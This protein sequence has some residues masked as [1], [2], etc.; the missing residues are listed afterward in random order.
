MRLAWGFLHRRAQAKTP[1]LRLLAGWLLL[2]AAAAAA[3]IPDMDSARG[4]QVF[5]SA[6]CI[7][8]HVLNGRGGHVGPNLLSVL[9]RAFTPSELAATMWNHAPTMWS[10][11]SERNVTVTQLTTQ[12]AADLLAMLYASRFF[13]KAGD[14][15][16]G[17]ELFTE[18]RCVQCHGITT[19]VNPKAKPLAQWQGLSDPVALVSANWN[20][21]S[22]MWDEN[23]RKGFHWPTLNADEM[24]DLLVYIRNSSTAARAEK[25]QFH[26]T[27]GGNGAE[28]FESKGCAMCHD[29]NKIAV[30]GMTLTAVAASMWNHATFLH[31]KPPAFEGDEM[32]SVLGYFWADQ[33]FGVNGNVARGRKVYDEKRCTE[34]HTGAGPGPKLADQAGTFNPIRMVSVIWS[35]GPLMK[36]MMEQRNIPW[37]TFRTGEMSDLLA[38]LNQ[39]TTN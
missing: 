17:K 36:G 6:G 23:K 4:E 27:T 21:S 26:I 34:C 10:R 37:P 14:A 39:Q 29:A 19:P 33:F 15:A 31:N 25:P 11:M 5:V 8:C 9:D 16:R 18:K 28:L 30:R 22:D 1:A 24:T 20:H 7:Q 32:R 13:E 38:F 12:N 35:H 3:T 2:S